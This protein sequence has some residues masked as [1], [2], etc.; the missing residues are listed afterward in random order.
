[1]S[2]EWYVLMPVDLFNAKAQSGIQDAKFDFILRLIFSLRLCVKNPAKNRFTTRRS[3]QY[4][5]RRTR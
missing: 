1:M 5:M 3:E 2:A 4:Q